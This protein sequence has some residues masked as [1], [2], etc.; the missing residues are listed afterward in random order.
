MIIRKRSRIGY[1]EVTPKAVYLNRRQHLGFH[2]VQI[3]QNKLGIGKQ[4]ILRQRVDAVIKSF[5]VDRPILE[6]SI[7][8]ARNSQ[9]MQK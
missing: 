3:I 4:E 9:Q 7:S 6:I 8:I 1:S 2:F 5:V